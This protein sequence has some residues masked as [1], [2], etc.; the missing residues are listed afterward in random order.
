[1][2]YR[3]LAV[4]VPVV[5]ALLAGGCVNVNSKADVSGFTQPRPTAD[6]RPADP[7]NRQDLLRENQQL[8]ERSTWLRK[9]N[10]DLKNDIVKKRNK[11]VDVRAEADRY[12]AERDSYKRQAGY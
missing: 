2:R 9:D 12:A 6:I 11:V 8:T 5:L 7:N 1:M 10:T 3:L 4:F